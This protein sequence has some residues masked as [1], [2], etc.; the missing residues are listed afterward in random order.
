V[1]VYARELERP[2]RVI[3]GQ[4]TSETDRLAASIR[5]LGIDVEA[6]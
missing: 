3:V 5:K 2:K 4:W 1:S 6:I